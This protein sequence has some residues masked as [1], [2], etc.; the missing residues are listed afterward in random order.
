MQ[1]EDEDLLMKR[2]RPRIISLHTGEPAAPVKRSSGSDVE[3]TDPC[4][5]LAMVG[6]RAIPCA[7]LFCTAIT[8]TYSKNTGG[9]FRGVAEVVCATQ[10]PANE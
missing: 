4:F 1:D 2:R 6:I 8:R 10:S 7:S 3:L 5:I 9:D